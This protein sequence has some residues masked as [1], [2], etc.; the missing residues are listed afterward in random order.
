MVDTASGK[1][2]VAEA[3]SGAPIVLLHGNP[4]THTVWSGVVAELMQG[5]RCIAPDMPG[6][7][8]SSRPRRADLALDRQG[9][10]V[11]GLLDALKLDRVH[12][13]IHD[14]GGPY[15][16]SFATQYPERL[17][18]LTIM[19]TTFFADYRWHFWARVFRIR[20]LG[21][22][23]MKIANGP[24]FRRELERGSPKMTREYADHAW[25]AYTPRTRKHVLRW[26]R[27]MTPAD[28]TGWDTRMLSAIENVPHQVIWGDRD[29][30][31]PASHGD[32]FGSEVHRF[33]DLGHWS[34]VE[35]PSRV[36]K[37]IRELCSAHA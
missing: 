2:H 22:L 6:Y 18:S 24:M 7:G 35:D 33:A 29:P 14:V 30:F 27:Q 19:N 11:A 20:G 34:M 26:Y 25:K 3:G 13:V 4:D 31:V 16:L 23:A 21:E 9:A 12:L 17:R 15:G 10:W 37:P 32:R 8:E 5:F 36:A 1:V 28:Y